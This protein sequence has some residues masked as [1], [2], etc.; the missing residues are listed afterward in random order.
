MFSSV[1]LKC[2]FKHQNN[3]SRLIIFCIFN[4]FNERQL[5]ISSSY[6]VITVLKA[7]HS[8]NVKTENKQLHVRA[9]SNA[10]AQSKSN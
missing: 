4:L 8:H 1:F 7:L 5:N 2:L 6:K 10:Q 3:Y 9:K